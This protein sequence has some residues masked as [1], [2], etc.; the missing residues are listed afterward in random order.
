MA[1]PR[2]FLDAWGAGSAIAIAAMT[3]LALMLLASPWIAVGDSGLARRVDWG[4]GALRARY[5][6]AFCP[7]TRDEAAPCPP[8]LVGTVE[9]VQALQLASIGAIALIGAFARKRRT[10]LEVILIDALVMWG[11]LIGGFVLAV[12]AWRQLPVAAASV[13]TVVVA[14]A[15]GVPIWLR[16][17]GRAQLPGEIAV[18]TLFMAIAGIVAAVLTPAILVMKLALT[19]AIAALPPLGIPV[20]IVGGA[21]LAIPVALAMLA[22]LPTSRHEGR[23]W[24]H[25]RRTGDAAAPVK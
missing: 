1:S 8:E 24:D 2:R 10:S 19:D 12:V 18:V 21:C 22:F 7:A 23:D 15:T 14:A 9:L 17:R 16:W 3:A 11:S 20:A 5:A 25:L 13:A 6:S 4:D